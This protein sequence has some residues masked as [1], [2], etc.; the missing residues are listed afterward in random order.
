MGDEI[1]S[2]R[3]IAH[4]LRLRI[5]SL[6]T[7]TAMSAAEVGRAL[8]VTQANAS[9]H[10]RQL[11]AADELVEAGEEKIRGGL[12]KRYTYP[13]R[14]VRP[15]RARA[16][17]LDHVAYV[18]AIGKELQRRMHERLR[19]SDDGLPN[20]RM[21]DLEGWLSPADWLAACLKLEEVSRLVHDGNQRPGTPG[22]VHVSFTALAFRMKETGE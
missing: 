18:Q 3:A 6:L 5:L 10:L 13:H 22:T 19:G 8:G 4:P 14:R 17:T 1:N 11:L 2:L 7:G 16:S 9:Y 15:P 12:A 21:S 20:G